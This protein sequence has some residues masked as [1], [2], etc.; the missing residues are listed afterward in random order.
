[1]L[2]PKFENIPEQGYFK[3]LIQ[4]LEGSFVRSNFRKNFNLDIVLWLEY[5][6]NS[7]VGKGN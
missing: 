6:S 4:L 7:R 3:Y 1:M 5:K 2:Q